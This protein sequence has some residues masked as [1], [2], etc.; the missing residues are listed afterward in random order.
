MRASLVTVSI[1]HVL[2]PRVHTLPCPCELPPVRVSWCVCVCVYVQVS[3]S[4]V[5]AT[6]SMSCKVT[7]CVRV[8]V[9]VCPYESVPMPHAF[10]CACVWSPV[11]QCHHL[12]VSVKVTI[13]AYRVCICVKACVK[14][15]CRKHPVRCSPQQPV[16]HYSDMCVQPAVL[17]GATVC[18]SCHDKGLVTVSGPCVTA[19][20]L[21]A[22]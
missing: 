21:A 12:Y 15:L 16:V 7:T 14:T 1:V 13:C 17:P 8:I 18:E 5:C 4:T 19:L 20:S 22:H 6:A 11:S 2:S 10:E 9:H 3:V